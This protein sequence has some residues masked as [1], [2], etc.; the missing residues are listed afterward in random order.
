MTEID[1]HGYSFWS[2]DQGRYVLI[3]WADWL[4]LHPGGGSW[5]AEMV[6]DFGEPDPED[7]DNEGGYVVLIE[8]RQAAIDKLNEGTAMK[9]LSL[10]L[11]ATRRGLKGR[12][13]QP[14]ADDVRPLSD[15]EL[16]AEIE[17]EEA[18]LRLQGGTP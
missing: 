13:W 7:Y 14:P 3:R 6:R 18:R 11:A 2:A 9:R 1:E 5:Y 8:W 4:K 15:A 17:A 12:D 16:D 10:R